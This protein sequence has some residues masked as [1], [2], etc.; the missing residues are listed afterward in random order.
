MKVPYA[1]GEADAFFGGEEVWQNFSDWLAKVPSVNY[2]VFTN[3]VDTAVTAHLP[4]LGKGTPIDD[5]LKAVD[6]QAQGQ[7]Q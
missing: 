1:Y 3:E 6:S 5:V 2:G 4:T 7:I